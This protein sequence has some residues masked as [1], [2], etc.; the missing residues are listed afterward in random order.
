MDLLK[1]KKKEEEVYVVKLSSQETRT[2]SSRQMEIDSVKCN[3]CLKGWGWGETWTSDSARM[4]EKKELYR[5][6]CRVKPGTDLEVR[7]RLFT[8]HL[9]PRLETAN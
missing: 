3:S 8:T 5:S 7:A 2:V 1:K 6:P 9:Q 4:K